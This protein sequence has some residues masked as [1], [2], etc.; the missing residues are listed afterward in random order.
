MDT[1]QAQTSIKNLNSEMMSLSPSALITLFELDLSEIIFNSA[2][3]SNSEKIFRFHSEPKLI[4]NDIFW[5]GNRYIAAPIQA[6]GFEITTK[7]STP[8]PKLTIIS[9]D[10][11]IDTFT[12][13][14][15]KIRS[16]GD[17]VGAK[18]TRIRTF[19]KYLDYTNFP[20]PATR[21][22]GFSPDPYSEYPRDIYYIE[23]K[24]QENK[25][26]IEYE[27]SSIFDIQGIKLPG[28]LVASTRC[29]W[30]YRGAGCGYEYEDTS[31][32]FRQRRTAI[33]EDMSLPTQAESVANYKDEAILGSVI[34]NTSLVSPVDKGEWNSSYTY[35]VGDQV[36]IQINLVK[37]Y[38]VFKYTGTATSINIPPPNSIFWEPDECGKSIKSCRLRF[39]TNSYLPF[40]G[41]PGSNRNL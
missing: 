29:L 32:T 39:G 15:Q 16:L 5:Q 14:R 3:L 18:V 12:T 9:H 36:Y 40:G 37:Y 35:S 25:N 27:L 2:I 28:R 23:R 11:T 26:L 21:P 20:N 17:I 10:S 31:N 33:H 13:L 1:T 38:F 30:T 19:A 8:T 6:K 41:F 4:N 7:G 22:P 24:S 34:T